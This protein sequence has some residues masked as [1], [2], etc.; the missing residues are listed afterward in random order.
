M[1]VVD[2]KGRLEFISRLFVYLNAISID[3]KL[4]LVKL[5][6][7]HLK[8]GEQIIVNLHDEIQALS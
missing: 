3:L 8:A 4:F 6:V 1:L 7:Q 2:L 5:Y